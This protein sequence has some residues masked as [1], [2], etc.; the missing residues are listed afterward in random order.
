MD[1]LKDFEK[2]LNKHDIEIGSGEPPRYWYSTGNYVL[3]RIISGDFYKG[4]PQGRV[5]GLVG[6]SGAGKSFLLCNLMKSAQ[7][8]G[9]H[10]LTIDS[11]NAL[12][13]QFVEAIGVDTSKNYTY[14]SV[15]TIPQTSKVVSTFI[16]NYKKEYDVNEEAPEVLIC[17]DSL[18][19]LMTDAEEE[20]FEKGIT[21]GDMG[22]KNKQLKQILRTFVQ[23][24]K[25]LNISI[26]VTDGTYKNQEVTN[27][28]G[29]HMV[30]DAVKYSLSQIVMLTKLKL[31]DTGST[32][33]KGIKM[34]CE[35]YKTRFT[36]P[37][38]KVTIHVPYEDGMNP[39]SGLADVATELG[40]VERK[41][42]R[43]QIVGEDKSWYEKNIDE[44]AN[45]ILEKAKT[46]EKEFLTGSYLEDTEEVD[47]YKDQQSSQARRKAKKDNQKDDEST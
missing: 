3:N 29:L 32:D 26:V 38:Q 10:I 13:K 28:E 7:D 36:A 42:S 6:P 33:V 8:S 24:I 12:D 21:K 9:A 4:I 11:E 15:D 1:F 41:G 43:L 37:F 34:K 45:R 16:K 40:I 14:V 25:H 2:E 46:K 17:I 20:N 47:E 5:T 19:M 23:T 22:S 35:G 18:D 39:Y 31:K 30:K 27:G 44:H